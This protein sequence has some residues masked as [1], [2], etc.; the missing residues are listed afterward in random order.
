MDAV[1]RAA[2]WAGI[3]LDDD[4]TRLLGR[5]EE[6]LREEAAPA[7]ALGPAEVDR[8][9]RRHVADSLCF[10]AAWRGFPPKR[11]ADV[12]SGAGLPGLPLA[13][14]HPDVPVTLIE[15]AGRR[16]TLL[17]RAIRVL[18]LDN[19]DIISDDLDRVQSRWPVVVS[20]A[21]IPWAQADR[22]VRL[23]ERPGMVV[24]GGSHLTR[25]QVAGFQVIDIPPEILA[26]PAWLL[27]MARP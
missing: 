10:A 15:R 8:I 3:V 13:I 23:L 16:V 4:R 18:R 6:W 19:V 2:E 17:R 24:L 14:A 26:S 20:R 7:G 12:G 27:T 25:P 11:L 9:G 22:L 1:H 5:F 21:A